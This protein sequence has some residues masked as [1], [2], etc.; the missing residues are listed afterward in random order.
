MNFRAFRLS[1]VSTVRIV[2]I[3][4]F[5]LFAALS[6]KAQWTVINL[7]PPGM[8]SSVAEGVGGGRQVGYGRVAGSQHAILWN[9]TANS[10][11]DLNPTGAT[12]SYAFGVAL[13]QQV[14]TASFGGNN[15][16]ILWTGSAA[17]WVDLNPIGSGHGSA[18]GVGGG[19]QVGSLEGHA[20]LWTGS[21]AS[22]IDLHPLGATSSTAISVDGG[23]QAGSVQ[24]GN[25]THASLWSGT[26]Q[27]WID[28]H[29]NGAQ[30]SHC[31]GI[32]DG[33]Q[34]GSATVDG[35]D[36]ASLWTGSASSWRDLHPVGATYS[37]AADVDEG[38]QVGV[39]GIDGI[40]RA[41]F[42]GGTSSSWLDLHAFL[43][44]VFDGS[45]A[46][47]IWHDTTHTYIVGYG[48]NR[49][50]NSVEAVM[51]IRPND[52]TY[53]LPT[54]YTILQGLNFG[55]NLASLL[56]SDDNKVF[57]LCDELDSNGGIQFDSTLPAGTVNQLKFT[58]EGGA[59]RTD[60]SQFVR[61]FN[62]STNTYTNVSF[63]NTT[64]VD[65]VVEGTIT[66]GVANYYS[67]TREVKSTVFWVPLV[68]LDVADGWIQSC[69]QV[70][71]TMN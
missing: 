6:A 13:G 66:T 14:G 71:W 8:M 56:N 10:W 54:S 11:V 25:V 58:C 44:S 17:S 9:G 60:L 68:D 27:S 53:A 15:H 21:A 43:P 39:A 29:P 41:S 65:S 38:E 49:F 48:H 47:G 4:Y 28:L 55:G 62:Y 24:V 3:A 36:R 1:R 18:H 33:E 31:E 12:N 7:Q 22:W 23:Q 2:A 19:Q 42:W 30:R 61:M 34:V 16:A 69:D 70:L 51:W 35:I 52:G 63:Q 37:Y 67:G 5:S 46:F 40:E 64:L 57:V 26:A 32:G 50:T 20:S 59:S 45:Q